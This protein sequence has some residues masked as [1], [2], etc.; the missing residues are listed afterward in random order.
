MKIV[1]ILDIYN[2]V[3]NAGSYDGIKKGDEFVIYIEGETIIDPD[4]SNDLGKLEL[5]KAYCTATHVQEKV[6]IIRSNYANTSSLALAFQASLQ[7]I[8]NSNPY[9]FL[10]SEEKKIKIGDLVK[11]IKKE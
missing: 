10:S 3:I 8:Q 7:E 4:S 6:S 9:S 2:Y 11:L 1:K 5:P